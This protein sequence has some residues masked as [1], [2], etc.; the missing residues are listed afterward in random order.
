MVSGELI[1]LKNLVDDCVRVAR[2]IQREYLNLEPGEQAELID[3]IRKFAPR[4]EDLLPG[5][6][7]PRETRNG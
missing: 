5:K 4:L 3:Y 1:R 7:Q 2:V 6:P